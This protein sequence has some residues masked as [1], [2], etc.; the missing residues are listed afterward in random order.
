MAKDWEMGICNETSGFLFSHVCHHPPAG[1]CDL[2]G[3]PICVDHSHQ[4]EEA[5]LCTACA[6]KDRRRSGGGESERRYGRS[7][8]YGYHDPY[9]Y[10]GY[11]YGYGYYDDFHGSSRHDRVRDPNDFTEADAESLTSETDEGFESDMSES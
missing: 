7:S 6:K 11:Y 4:A 1:V 10:G 3:K 8:Y 5:S 2:C 9:F